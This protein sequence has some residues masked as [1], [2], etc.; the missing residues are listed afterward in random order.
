MGLLIQPRAAEFAQNA[1]GLQQWLRGETGSAFGEN[2]SVTERNAMKLSPIAKCVRVRGETF[3]MLPKKVFERME[4]LGRPGRREA[5]RHPL[6]RIVHSNPNP[7]MTSMQY[8]ELLSADIDLWGNHYAYIETGENSGRLVNLWRIRPDLVRIDTTKEETVYYVN[9]LQGHEVPFLRGDILHIPGL[10][11]DGVRGYSPIRLH[12]EYGEWHAKAVRY[13]SSFL[14]NASRPSG[15]L[16]LQNSPKPEAKKEMVKNLTASKTKTGAMVVIEGAA[17]YKSMSMPNDEAQFLETVQFQE[18]DWAGIYRVPQH[19]IGNLRKSTN[20]NI[21]HQDIEFVRDTI[22]PICERVEQAMDLQLL[23]DLPGSGRGG[24]TERSRFFVEC[25]LKGLLRGDTEARTEHYREMWNISAYTANQILAEENMEPYE[26]GD[27][28][29]VQLNMTT[30]KNAIKLASMP[31]EDGNPPSDD[32]VEDR[33]RVELQARFRISYSKVFRPAVGKALNRSVKD[34]ERAVPGLFDGILQG[35]ADGLGVELEKEFVSEY[36][37]A[38]AKRSLEWND[39]AEV[40]SAE[41][42]RA[43]K[44][45]LERG[46][47]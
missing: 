7:L 3:A 4:I 32:T 38:M 34:R 16:I 21:E 2:V 24:G 31:D 39:A 13:G 14:S 29:F 35:L 19:K 44:A 18:E 6:Y 42:D 15:L 20:N 12:R 1:E 30:V 23:S 8:F 11:F 46:Q 41:L 22:Q 33:I 37:G 25:E 28:H 36:L 26:G 40:T 27:E 5:P 45:I 10:G 9:D 17:E 43:V 47:G